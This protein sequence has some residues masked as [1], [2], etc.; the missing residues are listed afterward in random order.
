[1]IITA[2]CPFAG[3][4]MGIMTAGM[5]LMRE[6]VVSNALSHPLPL[7]HVLYGAQ[8]FHVCAHRTKTLL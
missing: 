8:S 7:R 6:T 1:M 5:D 3:A 2:V 4:V